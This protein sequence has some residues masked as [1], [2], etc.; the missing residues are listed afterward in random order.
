MHDSSEDEA[1]DED[2]SASLT[3]LTILKGLLQ[4]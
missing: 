3:E 4:A 1:E 2:L